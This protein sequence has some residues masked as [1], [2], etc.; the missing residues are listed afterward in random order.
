MRLTELDENQKAQI[1][2][3]ESD[4]VRLRRTRGILSSQV[5]ALQAQRQQD[6]ARIN[7]LG[8]SVQEFEA[9]NEQQLAQVKDLESGLRY[10]Q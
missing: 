2:R 3:L 1:R 6:V 7:A 8:S 4:G 9:T 10:T 5:A